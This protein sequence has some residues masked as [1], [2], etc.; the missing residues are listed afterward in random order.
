MEASGCEQ[1]TT[2]YMIRN[3]RESS[4]FRPRPDTKHSTKHIQEQQYYPIQKHFTI[5]SPLA[6]FSHFTHRCFTFKVILYIKTMTITMTI[7]FLPHLRLGK[8]KKKGKAVRIRICR[9]GY[10]NSH[11]GQIYLTYFMLPQRHSY[12]STPYSQKPS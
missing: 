10:G 12:S 11:I 8:K 1:A 5:F 2:E 4:F 6:T 9:D 7:V 3:S